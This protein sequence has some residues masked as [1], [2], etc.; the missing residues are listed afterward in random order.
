MEVQSSFEPL[1]PQSLSSPLNRKSDTG[2]TSP[3]KPLKSISQDSSTDKTSKV[4]LSE[5]ADAVARYEAA[6]SKLKSLQQSMRSI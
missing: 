3:S 5:L 4:D 2:V 1:S 6:E